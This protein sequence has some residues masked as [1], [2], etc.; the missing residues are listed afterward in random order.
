MPLI[1]TSAATKK[2]SNWTENGKCTDVTNRR[3]RVGL[4]TPI[5][6]NHRYNYKV[7]NLFWWAFSLSNIFADLITHN[8]QSNQSALMTRCRT[9]FRHQ[10]GIFSGESQM[11][12]TRN[13]TWAGSEEGRLF[14]QASAFAKWTHKLTTWLFYFCLFKHNLNDK[15]TPKNSGVL[16]WALQARTKFLD[17]IHLSETTNVAD[18]FFYMG[19]SF[20]NV[21]INLKLQ[22]P[23]CY[24]TLYL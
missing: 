24:T 13:A 20:G 9:D 11:S 6:T 2:S 18:Q 23:L 10:C 22:Y 1:N 12:F 19:G 5:C 15:L 14:L 21:L 16:S 7:P 4:S 17:F 3:S 8:Y